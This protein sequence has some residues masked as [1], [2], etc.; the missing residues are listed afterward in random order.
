MHNE[1]IVKWFN[2]Y[3]DPNKWDYNDLKMELGFLS[4][5]RNEPVVDKCA[6]SL[7]AEYNDRLYI[8]IENTLERLAKEMWLEIDESLER[9]V[10]RLE[11][12]IARK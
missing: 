6:D 1:R 10:A 5:G 8:E 2:R 3:F 9:R 11:K 7:G 4:A 12:L